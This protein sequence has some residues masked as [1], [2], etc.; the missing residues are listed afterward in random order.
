MA[1]NV[2]KTKILS[3]KE[4]AKNEV[5]GTVFQETAEM[6]ELGLIITSTLSWIK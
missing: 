2:S 4:N 1:V 6:K 5:D 3:V